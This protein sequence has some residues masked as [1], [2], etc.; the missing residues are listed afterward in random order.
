MAR[1][2]DP[3][4]ANSQFFLM[5][6]KSESLDKTYSIWGNTVMGFD[7]LDKPLIGTVGDS[8]DWMPDRMDTV[9]IASDLPEADRPVVQVL[10]TDHAAFKGW[11]ETQK[12]SDGSYP[13]ICDL[14]VPTRVQ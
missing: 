1:T 5:R 6:A 8:P 9:R 14:F 3:N 11:L 12:E 4:S 2:S 7:Y 10:R 13:K